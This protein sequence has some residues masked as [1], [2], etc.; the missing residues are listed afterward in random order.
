MIRDTVFFETPESRAIYEAL[1]R[2]FGVD[3]IDLLLDLLGELADT[4]GLDAR[5][6]GQLQAAS[7]VALPQMRSI[8]LDQCRERGMIEGNIKIE[9]LRHWT[10][11]QTGAR[12]PVEWRLH[13]PA[14][15]HTV[16]ALLDAQELDSSASTGAVYWEGLS[17]LLHANGNVA[18]RGYL[19]MTGY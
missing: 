3:K 19:E 5:E 16:R 18:G 10:S 7:C 14:G 11:P 13:S 2:K 1:E 4:V 12:Y 6:L 8:Y 15:R 17:D 9:P